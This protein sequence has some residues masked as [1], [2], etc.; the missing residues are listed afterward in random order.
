MSEQE[1]KRRIATLEQQVA[2][3]HKYLKRVQAQATAQNL[4]PPGFPRVPVNL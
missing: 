3:L 1:M 4:L 2:T